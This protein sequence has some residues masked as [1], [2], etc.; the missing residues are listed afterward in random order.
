ML[1]DGEH[2]QLITRYFNPCGCR[3]A[4]VFLN[5]ESSL[6]SELSEMFDMDFRCETSGY[7]VK[8]F[9]VRDL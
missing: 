6:Q 7:R 1:K 3:D 8:L 4:F 5:C 2:F 9:D